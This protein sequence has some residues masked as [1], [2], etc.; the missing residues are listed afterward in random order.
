M[1]VRRKEQGEEEQGTEVCKEEGAGHGGVSR[2][3]RSRAGR[4]VRRKEQGREVCKEEGTGQG[5]VS[6]GRRSRAGR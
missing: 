4:C 6:R 3:R 1:C 2:G 5:G